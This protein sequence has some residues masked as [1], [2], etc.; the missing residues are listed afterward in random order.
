[1][2]LINRASMDARTVMSC[3]YWI[4]PFY[5]ILHFGEGI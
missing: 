4:E 1:M 3:G 5:P 2:L